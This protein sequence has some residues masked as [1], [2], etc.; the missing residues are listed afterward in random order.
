MR[1]IP[2]RLV[3]ILALL[4]AGCAS[5]SRIP[6]HFRSDPW[7]KAW[8]ELREDDYQSDTSLAL[9][10][11]GPLSLAL[12]GDINEDAVA[13][14][15]LNTDSQLGD[16]LAIGMGSLP[17]ILGGVSALRG[18]GARHL[19]TA[20]EAMGSTMGL[21]YALKAVTNRTRPDGSSADSFPSGH[22]SLSFAG[23][24]WMAR[25]I[26][27]CADSKWGYLAYIPAT[28]VGISR[29]EADRHHLSDIVFGALLGVL[30]TNL[31][32]NAHED[33][34]GGLMRPPGGMVLQC[35]PEID[36]SGA[37][38]LGLRLSF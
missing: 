8:K 10:I 33:E 31:I 18:E 32:W 24:T 3:C 7:R 29:M 23:A 20:T 4:F 13:N 35:G 12:E 22:T 25:W 27:E 14:Q 15:A 28:Y 19:E 21:T 9:A 6:G 38:A 30:T 16:A 34:G 26:E 37:F 17:I 5:H 36:E 2:E 11:A 1:T